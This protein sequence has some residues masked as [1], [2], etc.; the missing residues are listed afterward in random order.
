MKIEPNRKSRMNSVSH[1]SPGAVSEAQQIRRVRLA[2][3]LCAVGFGLLHSWIYLYDIRDVDG[4]SYL[5]MGDAF[6]KG[7]WSAAV[8]AYWSPL[9]AVI[10]GL[11]VEA[12]RPSPVWE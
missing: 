2:G 8:N 11:A 10:L 4:V 7:D 9:Y 3:W 1:L 12:F 6:M 5:D